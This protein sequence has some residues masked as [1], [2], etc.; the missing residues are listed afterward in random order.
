MNLYPKSKEDPQVSQG[1][2]FSKMTKVELEIYTNTLGKK[3][4]DNFFTKIKNL[5]V[6]SNPSHT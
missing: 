3:V 6:Q 2:D 1:F 4:T 5:D